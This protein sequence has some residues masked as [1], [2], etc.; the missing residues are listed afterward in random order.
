[1]SPPSRWDHYFRS[2]FGQQRHPRGS[3]RW[4]DDSRSFRVDLGP[5]HATG[6]RRQ[7]GRQGF[8]TRRDAEAALRDVIDGVAKGT[9]TTRSSTS[10]STFFDGGIIG[11]KHRLRPTTVY[12]YTAVIE[13]IKAELGRVKLQALV[14]LQVESF[15]TLLIEF[16]RLSSR[17]AAASWLQVQSSVSLCRR[18]SITCCPRQGVLALQG[19]PHAATRRGSTEIRRLPAALRWSR[20]IVRV[21]G[22]VGV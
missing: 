21:R 1:M 16:D 9:A 10:A 20:W 4:R 3:V 12:G 22:A 14:P 7:V 15:S 2:R 5:D 19:D 6:R 11:Q 17:L 18:R 8:R 13:H